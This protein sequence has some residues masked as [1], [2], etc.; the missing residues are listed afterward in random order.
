[1]ICAVA[2][3]IFAMPKSRILATVSPWKSARK[4]F[5]GLRSQWL[6]ETM[7]SFEGNLW[8]R[9]SAR[10]IG[11]RVRTSFF[12]PRGGRPSLARRMISE[13]SVS[14]SSH[15]RAMKGTSTPSFV[16]NASACSGRTTVGRLAESRNIS[17][18]SLRK[19]SS[20]SVWSFEASDGGIL[21]HLR[22]TG[23][24][25]APWYAR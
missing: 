23:A 21:R 25:N 1:M 10:A 24:R 20:S 17:S 5:S 4:M 9:S 16:V 12:N 11:A 2:A 22:A 6:M 14:P 18:A 15:S 13:S 7:P 19:R 8:A 3:L